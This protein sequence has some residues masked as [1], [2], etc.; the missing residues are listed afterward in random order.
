MFY[1]NEGPD[2]KIKIN[3][4]TWLVSMNVE[5]GVLCSSDMVKTHMVSEFPLL[6]A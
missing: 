4:Q 2:F 3:V 1:F 6:F 5:K